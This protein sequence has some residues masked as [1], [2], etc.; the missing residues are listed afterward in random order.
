[1]DSPSL[2]RPLPA[3]WLTLWPNPVL[4]RTRG[5]A[6][7]LCFAFRRSPLSCFVGHGTREQT[8]KRSPPKKDRFDFW[9][10]FSFGVLLGAGIG[11]LYAIRLFR[12]GHVWLPLAVIFVLAIG[13]GVAAGQTKGAVWEKIREYLPPWWWR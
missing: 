4:E 2:H 12:R 5:T 6:W 1:M 10:D 9:V 11:I 13:M 7:S 8:V 3:N